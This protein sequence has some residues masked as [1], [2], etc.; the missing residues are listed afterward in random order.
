MGHGTVGLALVKGRMGMGNVVVM[1]VLLG[2]VRLQLV[3]QRA[4]RQG[5]VRREGERCL[6]GTQTI[7]MGQVLA[8]R[9][10]QRR[11]VWH[12]G[13]LLFAR[14]STTAATAAATSATGSRTDQDVIVSVF[15]HYR[16]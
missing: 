6:I 14:G 5:R 8:Q 15:R 4:L 9:R 12:S 16:C 2:G 11:G 7:L 13:G 1:H 10:V 3:T